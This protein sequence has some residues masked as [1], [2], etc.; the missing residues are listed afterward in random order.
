MKRSFSLLILLAL[1]LPGATWLRAEESVTRSEKKV[2]YHGW[3]TRDSAYVAE[4]WA[5]MEQMPFDG[6]AIGIALDRSKPTI[7]DGSTANLLGWQVF[8][9]TPV[10]LDAFQQAIADLQKPAWT[11]FTDNFL[12][13]A[14]ASRDQDHG[15]SWFDDE[16]WATIENNWR[17]L[18]TIARDGGCRGL[19]LDPE[20]YDYEC[21]LFSYQNHRALRGDRSFEDYTAQARSRGR[22]LGAAMRE[23][24]P[25]IT[26]GLLYGYAL[27]ARE[28]RAD[29]P[30]R[31]TRYA[32]LPAFLDGLLEASA[33]DAKFVDLWEFGHRYRTREQF[34]KGRAEIKNGALAVSSNPEAYR[35][36]LTPG[37]SLRIDFNPPRTDW[38]TQYLQRN[39]FSPNRFER[40]LRGA[41][42]VSDRYVWIYSEEGPE[43]FPRA[44][45]PRPYLKAMR[46]AREPA[47]LLS[48]TSSLFP[49]SIGLAGLVALCVWVPAKRARHRLTET[50]GRSMR[51]LMVTGIFPPDRGGPASYVPKMAAALVQRGHQVE[52]ICLSDLLDH[53]DSAHPFRVHRLARRQFW[54]KRVCVTALQIWRVARR[55][56]LVYVNGLGAESA[57]GAALAGRPT[58]HKIVG[59]YA[60]ERA[61][62]RG[63]FH[64][65]I[66]EY[67]ASS[68]S[69]LLR[70]LDV[71]RTTPLRL[72]AGVIVPSRY[73]KRIV[74]GWKI[75]ADNVRVVPNAILTSGVADAEAALPAWSGKTLI[76]VCRL[77]PWKGV[78][79]LVRLLPELPNTRLVVA[80]DGHLRAELEALARSVGVSDRALFLGDV[81]HRLIAGYLAQVD[82][83]VLNSTYEGLPHVV[84]EAIAAGI[85][86]IA[87]NA[88]GTGEVVEHDVTGLLVPVGDDAALRAAVEQ[89][90][91]D[92][93]LCQRLVAEAAARSR[94]HFDFE[95]MVNATEATLQSVGAPTG[96][97][98]AFATEATP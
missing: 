37:M 54:P 87:T 59:D 38:Q 45:L 32:L 13:L 74:T 44:R 66:D 21:E 60:W 23:L 41:L 34:R 53:D 2:I 50:R 62:G 15:L 63:W 79:A 39:F 4:H 22:Q 7:G 24:F 36:A 20:H 19:L 55:S 47:A 90:W 97:P 28:V 80:G 49:I 85:P 16:R 18:L 98:S 27:A 67:Q 35:A 40:A 86:V 77:V 52:V 10:Q 78:A 58:I 56:H 43:F 42:D 88:G 29:R 48:S 96:T 92:P 30:L 3:N 81:P 65:T 76:T 69:V 1:I 26:V 91:T 51:I 84:L 6:T 31:A 9:P 75:P 25:D 33:P 73:L 83:F 17:V 57:L 94:V 72:A 11:R 14:I 71:V 5:E 12:P 70:I 61:V 8:G 89:L 95:A 93:A 82:A 64:G 68:K 46:N